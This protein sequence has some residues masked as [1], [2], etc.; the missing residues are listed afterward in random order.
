MIHKLP[1]LSST[2]IFLSV[3]RSYSHIAQLRGHCHVCVKAA[4]SLHLCVSPRYIYSIKISSDSLTFTFPLYY[5]FSPL[6][7]HIF[8][9]PL[10]KHQ[11]AIEENETE[12]EDENLADIPD[13]NNYEAVFCPNRT[14]K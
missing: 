10:R 11:K 6:Y 1:Q 14:C 4:N 7:T 13:V 12:P 2:N 9:Y 3:A 8:I 5:F